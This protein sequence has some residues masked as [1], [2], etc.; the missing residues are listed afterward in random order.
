MK[1]I[2]FLFVLT[3][4]FQ[5]SYGQKSID[6]LFEKYSDE[7]GFTSVVFSGNL[8]R[9][10]SDNDDDFPSG[11]TELR[12]LTQEN[13][14]MSVENF[15][16]LVMSDINR[17][18]YEEFMSVKEPGQNIK[19]LVRSKGNNIQE[20]LLIAGGNDNVIVQAKGDISLSDARKFSEKIK[21]EQ[22]I[23]WSN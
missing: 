17:N 15:Y 5:I 6:N 2:Y 12:I 22:N 20:I 23:N 19:I 8:L 4:I 10:V 16:N 11:I 21:K 7:D 13:K 1:R 3:A 14:S 18:D 9:M